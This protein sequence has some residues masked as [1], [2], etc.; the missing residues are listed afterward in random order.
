[1]EARGEIK[2]FSYTKKLRGGFPFIVVMSI[3]LPAIY[4]YWRL[5]IIDKSPH[6]L[7]CVI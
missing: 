7:L 4:L 6:T 3:R 5:Y 2:G 1:M